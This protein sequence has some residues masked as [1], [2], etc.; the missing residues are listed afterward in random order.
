MSFINY[1]LLSVNFD[2][3]LVALLREVKYFKA[4][5]LDV[6]KSALAVYKTTL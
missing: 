5:G 2:P 1:T 6:V 3:E 4:M